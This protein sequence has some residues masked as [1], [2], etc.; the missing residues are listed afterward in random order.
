MR[1]WRPQGTQNLD[2]KSRLRSSGTPLER[3]PL[4]GNGPEISATPCT[5]VWHPGGAIKGRSVRVSQVSPV[6]PGASIR[7][8]QRATKAPC[9]GRVVRLPSITLFA[10]RDLRTHRRWEVVCANTRDAGLKAVGRRLLILTGIPYKSSPSERVLR[11]GPVVSLALRP[12]R[13]VRRES[14]TRHQ[15]G[16]GGMN[17]LLTPV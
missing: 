5:G 11:G 10:R 16:V 7:A 12:G 14:D 15:R 1:N 9:C 17:L 3:A 2:V 13:H 6:R 4:D 8:R